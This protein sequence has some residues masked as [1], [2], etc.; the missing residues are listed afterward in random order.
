MAI[1]SFGN[2]LTRDVAKGVNTKAARRLPQRVWKAAQRRL[3]SLDAA[4]TLSDL[5]LP[6]NQLKPLKHTMPGFYSIRVNDQY[7]I[8][9]QFRNG[10]AH[11]VRI[12]DYHGD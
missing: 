10:D 9:F 8:L 4:K 6:G 1:Q 2:D 11:A 5:A 7:R 12:E 3:D